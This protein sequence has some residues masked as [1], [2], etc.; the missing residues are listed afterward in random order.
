MPQ[1]E[2][3]ARP[4]LAALE[5][6]GALETM[7]PAEPPGPVGAVSI[8]RV[9]SRGAPPPQLEPGWVGGSSGVPGKLWLP[10]RGLWL[11]LWGGVDIPPP[12]DS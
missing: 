4:A 7:R 5:E 11:P 8:S 2:E 6:A 1:S 10:V 3:A 9:G 12:R